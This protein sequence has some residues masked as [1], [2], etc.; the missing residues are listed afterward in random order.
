MTL[1]Y[2]L[3]AQGATLFRWRSFM[4]FVILPVVIAAAFDS[5]GFADGHADFL[6]RAYDL[7]CIVISFIGLALRGLTVASA[8]PRTSGRNTREQRADSLNTTGAYS[9][10]RNPLYVANFLV[11]L[12]MLMFLKV[13]WL[14]VI[15]ALA[16]V[17]YYER[18][19]MAE[20][21]FLIG[22]FGVD[23]VE[24]ADRTPAMIPNF[25]LWKK[26]ARPLSPRKIL[27]GEYN[28]FYL[29]VACFY[30][31]EWCDRLL[32]FRRQDGPMTLAEAPGLYWTSFFA[33]GTLVFVILRT[34]KKYTDILDET[35]RD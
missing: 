14:V 1:R 3:E 10:V 19:V 20:E 12:G 21:D 24:W 6:G 28:G 5:K 27:R 29:I 8:A 7:S 23:Y 11:F 15:A 31:L 35:S 30:L 22:K 17:L 32:C 13:W 4:P 25:R 2:Q 34:L 33:V 9:I 26:P 16:Y 18:I